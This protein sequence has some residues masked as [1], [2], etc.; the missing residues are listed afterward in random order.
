MTSEI[1]NEIRPQN[2]MRP[3][4]R[5]A[6]ASNTLVY[7][8][9]KQDDVAPTSVSALTEATDLAT[10]TALNTSKASVTASMVGIKATITDLLVRISLIDAMPHFQG[11]LSRTMLEK[12]ETDYCANL[13]NFS[14]VTT[15]TSTLTLSDILSAI[16]SLEQRD[17]TGRLVAVLHPKPMGE[18]RKDAS[19][20]TAVFWSG[21][22]GG[23]NSLV[24]YQQG[25][26]VVNLFGVD[27]FQ[28][29]VVPTSDA[30]AKRAGAMFIP[31]EALGLYELWAA[32]VG[33]QRDESL[34]AAE[35]VLSACYG[36]TEIDDTR[37]QTIK[38]NS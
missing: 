15:A 25:G 26:F 3:F 18:L 10:N 30:G 38:S 16:S 5:V 2:V 35:V 8:F 34:L 31:N 4:F 24:N 20:Q 21:G 33:I 28:T 19:T 9:P 27:L 23:A 13:A 17:I 11:V 29:S 32:K 7:D 12:V 22:N 36:T 14:N 6:P 1:L 37:G